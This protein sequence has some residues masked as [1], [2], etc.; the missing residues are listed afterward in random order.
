MIEIATYI[1]D[2]LYFRDNFIEVF[3]YMT[4]LSYQE[5]NQVE[6]YTEIALLCKILSA[7]SNHTI[8]VVCR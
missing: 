8:A 5:I 7:V 4:A 3:V 1:Y 2:I 6:K